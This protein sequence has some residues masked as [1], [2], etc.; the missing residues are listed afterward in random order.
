MKDYLPEPALYMIR[1]H[2]FY[3]QHKENAYTHLMVE[4]DVEMFE[5]VKK[6]NNYDLY[7]KAPVKPDVKSLLPY[8]KELAAKYLPEKLSF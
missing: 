6:F 2:S 1:Y 7:T 4:K 5:W 8:Y 3:A